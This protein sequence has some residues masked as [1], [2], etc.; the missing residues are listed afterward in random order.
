MREPP[1][2][3]PDR[4]VLEAVRDHWLR[5]ADAVEHLPV[6]FGAWHWCVT[7]AGRATLFVT[8]DRLA[9]RHTHDSLD[10]AYRAAAALAAAGLEFVH[11]PSPSADGAMT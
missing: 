8:L 10:A 4:E 9:E 6:G 2:H 11:A 3:L 7:V 1:P 5:E